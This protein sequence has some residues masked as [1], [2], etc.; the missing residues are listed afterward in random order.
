[1][2][3]HLFILFVSLASVNS[4]A[5]GSHEKGLSS[6][7]LWFCMGHFENYEGTSVYDRWDDALQLS[8]E[9]PN[10]D[11]EYDKGFFYLENYLK[12]RSI[13]NVITLDECNKTAEKFL[14]Y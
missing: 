8:Y 11:E 4:F 10:Q 9:P 7:I 14:S 2:K 12:G 13:D 1:L 3:K 6:A 5:I